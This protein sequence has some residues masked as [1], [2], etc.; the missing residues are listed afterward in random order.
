MSIA[1]KFEVIADAVYEKGE[2]NTR[3]AAWNAITGYGTRTNGQRMFAE[4]DFSNF[5]FPKTI[6]ITASAQQMF[7]NY[8]GDMLPPKN[9]IDLSEL[10]I[11]AAS[12]T[13]IFAQSAEIIEIPDYGTPA[14]N[15]LAYAFQKCGKLETIEKIR[16]N[17]NTIFATTAAPSASHAFLGCNSLKN[18]T[19]EG[20]IGKD[21]NFIDCPNLTL[22]TLLHIIGQ[23]SRESVGTIS[24]SDES[25]ILLG[26]DNL[27][28]IIEKG[29]SYV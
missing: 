24:L 4:T 3:L 6:K 14:A 29:W 23:L 2:E 10:T 27:N 17:K 19:F 13:Y 8:K 28:S 18:V 7:Y 9:K 22:T 20:E 11:S 12:T 1:E 25:K 5:D 26:D 21:I 15:S 16:C